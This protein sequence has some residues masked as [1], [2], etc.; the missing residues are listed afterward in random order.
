MNRRR[1]LAVSG[2]F[3]AVAAVFGILALCGA[4]TGET[5]TEP[6]SSM[7]VEASEGLDTIAVEAAFHPDTASL[8]VW[9]HMTLLN[10]TGAALNEAVLRTWPNAFQSPDTSPCATDGL[11]ESCYPAGFSSGALVMAEAVAAMEGGDGEVV[12]YRYT[13]DAKTVLSLPLPAS[14]RAG[15]QVEL[16]LRYTVQIPQAA[17]R[18]GRQ[19]GFWALGNAFAI[20]AVWQNGGWRTDEYAPVGDPFLSDC[21]NYT[22]SVTAPDG[23]RC[24]GSGWPETEP[25]DGGQTLYRF[26]ARAVRD[27]ALVISDRFQTVQAMEDGVLVSVSASSAASAREALGYARQALRCYSER[28]GEYPYQS[29]SLAEIDFPMGGMEYPAMAMIASSQLS[30]GGASLEWVVAHEVAH[31][32]WYAVVGSDPVNQ[33]WQDEALCEFSL[34]DYVETVYGLSRRKELEA[35]RIEPAMRVTVPRGVTPGAPLSYFSSMSE[36]SLVVYNRGA[37]ML[38]ALDRAMEGGLDGFLKAYYRRY[39]F[40]RASREDF[41]AL[42]SSETGEDFAPLIT[43]YLDTYI[44]N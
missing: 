38:C 42:L 25:A 3:L 8:E 30:A 32:W 16:T 28:Y 29:L 35:T 41:E 24:V 36:Y 37:A 33:A 12:A 9:Q 43:D 21:A 10:R 31:Q 39:A 17:Y 6:P 40:S 18:F 34:L 19:N 13:D 4:F 26:H 15:A 11:Y 14:W 2:A 5:R 20:P 27:F 22:V 23:Y 7:L 1:A 44:H